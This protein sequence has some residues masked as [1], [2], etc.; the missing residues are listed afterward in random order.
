M[1]LGLVSILILCLPYV[2]YGSV[3]FSSV[4]LCL[5]IAG[6]L[7]ALVKEFRHKPLITGSNTLSLP[8]M[9]A[10]RYPL[11]CTVTCLLAL[12]LALIPHLHH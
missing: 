4:G 7:N 8:R 2:G 6:G 11:G 3:L 9:S 1:M 5:G 10:F 12:L